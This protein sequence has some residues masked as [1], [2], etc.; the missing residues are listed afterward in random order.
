MAL[1]SVLSGITSA[2]A[3]V[4]SQIA[5][6]LSLAP[7]VVLPVVYS[8]GSWSSGHIVVGSSN[9]SVANIASTTGS[10]EF[11]ALAIRFHSIIR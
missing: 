10:M 5:H 7:D 2:T 3:G 1:F 9:A 8:G 11:R 4:F 6:G